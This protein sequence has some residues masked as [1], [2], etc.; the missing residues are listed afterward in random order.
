MANELTVNVQN[1]AIMSFDKEAILEV[2]ADNLGGESL[3]PSDLDMVKIPTGGATSWQ[4]VPSPEGPQEVKEIRGI[5]L[6]WNDSR[7]WFKEEFDGSEGKI[8]DCFSDDCKSGYFTTEDGELQVRSCTGCPLAEWGS[9]DGGRGQACKQNRNLYILQEGSILPTIVKLSPTSITPVKQ[10]FLRL[11]SQG[12]HYA[13]VV[14]SLGLTKVKKDGVP[15][16]SQVVPQMV[17]RLT[18]EQ[19]SQIKAVAELLKPMLTRVRVLPD[20]ESNVAGKDSVSAV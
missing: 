15:A 14:T 1:Y 5:I 17:Q 4:D 6:A 10:Y 13:G 12:L 7:A 11:A 16:F 3:K 2:I 9:K 19:T 8:P 18:P 20:R